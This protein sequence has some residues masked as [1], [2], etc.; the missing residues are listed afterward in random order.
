MKQI[1]LLIFFVLFSLTNIAQY[2]TNGSAT[3]ESCN[4]YTLTQNLNTQSG[5][6]WN[7]NRINLSQSFAFTFDVFLGCSDGGADGIAFVMQPISTSVGGNGSGMGFAGI[8]PS[9]GVTLDTYQNSSPDNDPFYDHIAI[10]VNGNV[11]H[12]SPN[13]LTPLT[14][15]SAT[16][17]NVED[18]QLHLLKIVWDAPTT[19]MTV[20]FDGVLRLTATRDLVNT[21]F[22]GNTQVFWGFTGATGGLSNLQRFCTSL[23]PKFR[24]LP[25]QTRCVGEPINFF[26]STVTFGGILKRSWNF[27]DGSPIDSVNTDPVH[28][29]STG[30]DFTVTVTIL[31][32]D[33][34]SATYTQTI[35]VGGKP[36]AGFSISDSCVNNNIQFTDTSRVQPGTINNWYWNPGNAVTSIQQHPMLTYT[37]PGLK[38]IVL[39]VKTAEGCMSDTLYKTIL[40]RDRPVADFT[41]TDSLCQGTV[42]TFT[43]NSSL[44][45]GPVN[46]WLWQVDNV[47]VSNN[48][49]VLNH[50]FLTA[51]NHTVSLSTSGTGATNCYSPLVTRNVFVT[52]KPIAAIKTLAGCEGKQVQLFDSSYTRDNLPVTSWWWDLGNGQFSTQQNPIVTYP[53]AGPITL[54]LV[55]RNSRN[56]ASDTLQVTIN[57]AAKPV[58]KFG[59]SNPLCNSGTIQFSDSSAVPDAGISQWLWMN[60]NIVFSSLQ[61]PS[62]VFPVGLNIVGLS[63][64]SSAGCQSDTVYRAFTIKPKPQVSMVFSDT[65]KFSDVLF[66]AGEITNTGIT[67]W[68]WDFGDGNTSIANPATHAYNGNGA[69]VVKL[70]GISADGCSSDTIKGT[71]N[72]YG[73]NA[74]AG[75]DTIAA[76]MQPVQLNATGGITYE[77]TP[78]TGLNITSVPDPIATNGVDRY[79][80]LKAST[81]EGCES[82]DTILIKIY[83][84]PEIY[85][86]GAFTPNGDGTN[87]I[88]RA[89]PVGIRSFEYFAVYNRYGE[90]V[91]KTSDY[92][93]GW[94]GKMKGKE[95]HTGTFVWMVSAVDFLGRKMFKKGS[96]LLLH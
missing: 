19:T 27:G 48:S 75:N 9:V 17:N 47:P 7:N 56:C 53:V 95:Q 84:G 81:P 14:A 77:W 8:S 90:L 22:G 63:V 16:S 4:C 18:C 45:D 91:F 73:T 15:I 1:L 62:N 28:T 34:C 29:Y 71:I 37:T 39:A 23:L 85:V 92:N 30:G 24:L 20:F 80:F 52:D 36:V 41:F 31:A 61:N 10:Q 89:I 40:I 96:V 43:G 55:V 82:Y 32:R 11:N 59:L 68:H 79:Y 3:R 66:T 54:K 88:L 5:S 94:D 69:Y 50:T 78:S 70:Y 83:K 2:T 46:N 26:D 72:I 67:G 42:N 51:G 38:N 76:A 6:V 86:P 44:S 64:I 12:L 58:A 25:T 21:I 74:F 93:R 13:T 57:I 60:N 33:S 35:R 49:A 87:D 65:C